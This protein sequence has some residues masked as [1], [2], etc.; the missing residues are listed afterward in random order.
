MSES[1]FTSE[2]K[3]SDGA[4]LSPLGS[5]PRAAG[6]PDPGALVPGRHVDKCRMDRQRR[7]AHGD[8]ETAS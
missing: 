3:P 1:C 2:R 8:T 6:L 5:E 4:E 7:M